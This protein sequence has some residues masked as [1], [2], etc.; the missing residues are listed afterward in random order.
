MGA[1]L[2][3]AGLL[4]AAASAARAASGDA[5]AFAPAFELNGHE[6]G[7]VDAWHPAP[8]AHARAV[9]LLE[10]DATM[11]QAAKLAG[12]TPALQAAEAAKA[13]PLRGVGIYGANMPNELQ[14][15]SQ[16]GLKWF[17]TWT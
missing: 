3:L 17:Y 14:V 5:S 4:A 9:R 11:P 13:K 8:S 12:G 16:A 6:A 15:F 10:A 7:G 2:V 1:L